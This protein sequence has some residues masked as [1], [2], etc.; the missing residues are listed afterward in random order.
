MVKMGILAAFKKP[1]QLFLG[2]TF[3]METPPQINANSPYLMSLL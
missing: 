2:D 3:F 1:A